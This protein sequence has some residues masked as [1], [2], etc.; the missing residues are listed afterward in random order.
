MYYTSNK[1][2]PKYFD[3]YK[4]DTATW[5]TNMI[6]KNDSGYDVS[7]I[8]FNERYLLLTKTI[9]TDV[10]D[11]YL[12]D[13]SSK[14][15]KKI[16]SDSA[17]A[18]YNPAAFEIND[19]SFYYTTDEGKEFQY[20]VKSNIATGQKDKIFETNWNVAYMYLRENGN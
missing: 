4:M 13:A 20:L 11:L 18:S 16:S 12:F 7:N 17:G 15:M 14:Q 19:S 1:R 6:Y 9:T 3:L 10:N 5:A 2:D 8:S